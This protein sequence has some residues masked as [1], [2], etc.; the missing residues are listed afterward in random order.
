MLWCRMRRASR[1]SLC[2][3]L[4]LLSPMCTVS[5]AGAYHL[6]RTRA[7]QHTCDGCKRCHHDMLHLPHPVQIPGCK[8]ALRVRVQSRRGHLLHEVVNDALQ[9]MCLQPGLCSLVCVCRSRHATFR[10]AH[11]CRATNALCDHTLER[12]SAGT[13]RRVQLFTAIFKSSINHC[14]DSFKA[15]APCMQVGRF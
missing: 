12:R 15:G 8:L 6:R 5:S 7:S 4:H 3:A 9:T 13:Q 11:V 1:A 2:R 14:I 10:H